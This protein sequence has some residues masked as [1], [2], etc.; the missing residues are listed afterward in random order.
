ML[1]C[2]RPV[3]LEAISYIMS[4]PEWRTAPSTYAPLAGRLSASNPGS[5]TSLSS[6]SS[7][8]SLQKSVQ[9][10]IKALFTRTLFD[11]LA[12][13]VERLGFRTAPPS[14][15]ALGGK[16]IA[17]AFF[18]CQGVAETLIDIWGLQPATV[19]RVFSEFEISRG[20]DLRDISETVVCEFPEPLHSFGLT[21][22]IAFVRQMKQPKIKKPPVGIQINWEGPW[23]FRWCGRDSDLL[24]VFFKHYHILMCD[25]LS[26]DATPTARLCAPGYVHVLA[27]MLSLVDNT[28]HRNLS[29]PEHAASTATFDD[30]LNATAAIPIPVRGA[31]RGMSENK[32][33]VLLRDVLFESNC[34]RQCRVL[35]AGSFIVM[36]KAA[37]KKTRL[38]DADACFQLCDLVEELLP[39]LTRAV[40][41][42]IGD[43]IDW[44][45][46][47]DAAQT[48][49]QSENNMTEL[50][51]L[52][53][54][55]TTWPILVEDENRK[56]TVCLKWLLST[57]VWDRFFCHWCPMVR[58]YYMRLICWRLGR[59]DG[60]T[61]MLDV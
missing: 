11:T 41:E 29:A 45:F 2:D 54:V 31:A 53:F 33:V 40:K 51:V 1:G 52:T 56:G 26:P 15:V 58:A 25:Y 50:R 28:I 18:F 19:R 10:N 48:M 43:L 23:T 61:S 39:I 20:T 36:L 27:Q 49:L 46:W 32:L 6:D 34:L 5:S 4:R 9:H 8:F 60:S 42:G 12:Y 57:P 21:S 30:L 37:V 59:Y 44:D 7:K 14:L 35:F 47:L 13:T 17:Y 3:Y 55:Y 16:T 22:D 24:F 38:Y